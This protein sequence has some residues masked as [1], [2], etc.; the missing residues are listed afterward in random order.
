MKQLHGLMKRQEE[1]MQ[2][3]HICESDILPLNSLEWGKSGYW[4]NLDL[5]NISHSQTEQIESTHHILTLNSMIQFT[6]C[7][8]YGAS[9]EVHKIL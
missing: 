3:K 8:L 9:I 4:I 2:M 5:N 1:Q 6:G 7:L